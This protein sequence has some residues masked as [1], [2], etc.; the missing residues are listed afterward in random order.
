MANALDPK[1]VARDA[2]EQF[3]GRPF[4]QATNAQL[5]WLGC[6]TLDGY[7]RDLRVAYMC[8]GK[9]HYQVD[10]AYPYKNGQFDLSRQIEMDARKV[11]LCALHGV[12]LIVIPYTVPVAGY[13][14]YIVNALDYVQTAANADAEPDESDSVE[15]DNEGLE[16]LRLTNVNRPRKHVWNAY[17][18]VSQ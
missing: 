3:T 1:D 7:N 14:G 8:H 11:F 4:P 9:H 10:P 18:P 13:T 2:F 17:N 15:P 6:F 16:R 5:P 12:A